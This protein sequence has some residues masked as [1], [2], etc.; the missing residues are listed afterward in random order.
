MA[1]IIDLNERSVTLEMRSGKQKTYPRSAVAYKNPAAGDEVSLYQD[2][3]GYV[4]ID[5]PNDEVPAASGKA[6]TQNG[7]SVFGITGFV[8]GIIA[9]I[10]SVIP[11]VNNLAFFIGILAAVLS[12]IG[13]LSHKSKGI[14]IAGLILGILSV[15]VTLA[16]QSMWSKALD[17]V[18][19]SIDSSLSDATGEN[20]DELLADS[21]SVEFGSF[22]ASKDEYGFITSSLPVTVTNRE[23]ELKSYSIHIEAVDSNGSRIGEDYIYANDLGAGQS[24]TFDIFQFIEADKYDA[25]QSASFNIV[26]VSMY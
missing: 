16:L 11:I 12:I 18:S 4:Y 15:V 1:K 9:I 23:S 7:K 24:Q 19:E 14:S 22:S 5:L 20:T 26:E 25:Y 21:V 17:D 8:L 10:F 2:E 13:I 3:D 6:K